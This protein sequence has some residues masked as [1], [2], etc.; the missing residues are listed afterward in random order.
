MSIEQF[1]EKNIAVSSLNN[2]SKIFVNYLSN[3]KINAIV[4]DEEAK[5]HTEYL[6]S[7]ANKDAVKF[8]SSKDVK[9]EELECLVLVEED[10]KLIKLAEKNKCSVLAVSD[11]FEKYFSQYTYT[12]LIGDS[13][14][15]ASSIL[16]KYFLCKGDVN[17]LCDP[18][19]FDSSFTLEDFGKTDDYVVKLNEERIQIIQK[20]HFNFLV[21]FDLNFTKEIKEKINKIIMDQSENDTLI[22]NIDNKEVKELYKNIKDDSSYKSKI[23]PVSANKILEEGLSFINN[24][25]YINI[26]NINNEFEAQPFEYLDGEE[27]KINILTTLAILLEKGENI[28]EALESLN[29]YKS[30]GSVFDIVAKKENLIFVNDINNK[31]KK[32]TMVFFDNIYW[33]LCSDNSKFNIEN[34]EELKKHF[35]KI[36]KAFLLGGVDNK[37]KKVL[38]DNDVDFSIAENIDVALK[39]ISNISK[40]DKKEEKFAVLLS[41]INNTEDSEIYENYSKAFVNLVNKE[42]NND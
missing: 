2:K 14:S 40:E 33:L 24:E 16:F 28:E 26:N 13:G 37:V 35:K 27:N 12:A 6:S 39:D 4:L 34:F 25:F 21:L 15:S 17:G 8:S 11:F 29:N 32:Q 18:A 5:N 36:K 41:S 10:K 9:W 20:S 7:L 31:N 1:K 19:K 22:L 3:N 30:L 42:E 38:K 23:I